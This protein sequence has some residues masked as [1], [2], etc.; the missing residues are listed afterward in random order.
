MIMKQYFNILLCYL[1][2]IIQAS[3]FTELNIIYFLLN[4]SY[5]TTLI[6]SMLW[7]FSVHGNFYDNLGYLSVTHL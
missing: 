6:S 5:F 7:I 3:Y 2:E 1:K 4:V